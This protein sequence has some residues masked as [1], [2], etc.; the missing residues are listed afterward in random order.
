MGKA[1]LIEGLLGAPAVVGK[2]KKALGYDPDKVAAG[3]P[4]V[5]EPVLQKDPKT[6]KEFY[7]KGETEESLAVQKARKAAQ[8][9]IDKGNY[10]PYF[11]PAKRFYADPSKYDIQGNTLTDAMPKKQATIDKY[12]QM[13]RNPEAVGR[14][15]NAFNIGRT[16]PNTGRWYAMGQ[17]EQAYIDILGPEKGR[18][19]F[20]ERFADSMAAT[21]GG[22]NPTDN[23]INAMYGNYLREQGLRAPERSFEMPFP[24]GGRFISGN[25]QKYNYAINDGFGLTA[26]G[27]PK[28]FNF[29]GNFLGDI[30]RGTVDEQMMTGWDPSGKMAQPPGDSYG[31]YEAVIRDLAQKYGL[32]GSAE[33]QDVGWGGLK[34]IKDAAKT[35]GD[36]RDFVNGMPMIEHVNEAI[37]RTSRITGRPQDEAL[38][39]M[40]RSKGPVYGGA[41]A[42]VLPGLLDANEDPEGDLADYAKG[43]R[44]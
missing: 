27:T 14:L 35:G 40:I 2:V 16:D 25:M 10:T 3:Y 21:T 6:G 38:E 30:N 32:G 44:Y 29:S 24:I 5:A 11:D 33:F 22:S 42:A 7:A 19:M 12:E 18:A 34:A 31:V 20:K 39:W 36:P 26:D 8:R 43:L 28:R 4:D 15:E 17:L 9:D 41:G 23:F 13:A 37:E 1:T